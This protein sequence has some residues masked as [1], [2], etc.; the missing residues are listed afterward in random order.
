MRS[1]VVT[2][3]M[4]PMIS[5]SRYRL[6]TVCLLPF[7]SLSSL[8]AQEVEVGVPFQTAVPSVQSAEYLQF[9][10]NRY[11]SKTFTVAYDVFLM[12]HQVE[13]AYEVAKA[14]VKF[15]PN[16]LAW[17]KKLAQAALWSN[18]S[19][20]ALQQWLYFYQHRIEVNDYAPKI[21]KLATELSNYQIQRMMIA[22]LLKKTPNDKALKLKYLKTILG[23]GRAEEG[24][25]Y[26]QQIPN[27]LQDEDYL[28]QYAYIAR[29]MANFRLLHQYLVQWEKINPNA[30]EPQIQDA[31]L[32]LEQGHL[33]EAWRKY[34]S[35]ASQQ[36]TQLDDNF[37]R[38]YA[39]IAVL[40]GDNQATIRGYRMLSNSNGIDKSELINL[41]TLESIEG[42]DLPVYQHARILFKKY[43]LEIY[44]PSIISLGIN[45][46]KLQEVYQFYQN[47]TPTQQFNFGQHKDDVI[48]LSTL[49]VRMRELEKAYILWNHLITVYP[50]DPKVQENFL[51]FLIDL[52]EFTQLDRFLLK[53]C[54]DLNEHDVLWKI[55]AVSLAQLGKY[56]SALQVTLKHADQIQ[57]DY[58][59]LMDL[60]DLY[61]QTERRYLAY[62]TQREASRLLEHELQSV[63]PK[64]YSSRQLL[65][66]S[67]IVRL[68]GPADMSYQVMLR[69]QKNL[70]K[71]PEMNQQLIAYSL[72]QFFYSLSH[73]LI[74][75]LEAQQE[76]VPEWMEQT[77]ALVENDRS[78]LESLLSKNAPR[79]PH[80]DRV[81]AATRIEE[82]KKAEQ[83]AYQGL[84]DHPWDS[85]MY[86]LFQQ[87][88]LPRANRFSTDTNYFVFSTLQGPQNK[89]QLLY[90]INPSLSIDVSNNIWLPKS[91]NQAQLT[92]IPST[93]RTT[94]IKLRKY[95]HRGW[96]EVMGGERDALSNMAMA[97]L[98]FHRNLPARLETELQLNYHEPAPETAAMMIGGMKNSANAIVSYNYNSYNLLDA[99]A[100]YAHYQGQNRQSLGDGLG[101]TL[102][103]RHQ[104]FLSYPDWNANLYATTQN[105][106]NKNT[107]I[108]APLQRL[109]PNTVLATPAFFMP[110]SYNQ[111]AVTLDVGQRYREEYSQPWRPFADVGL[112]NS[113]AFGIG[114]LL[115]LGMS[116]RLLGRDK[117][118]FYF[119]YSD[120]I[121]QNAQSVYSLGIRYD[122]YY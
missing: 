106:H 10:F 72:E 91:Y 4:I 52:H 114:R 39:L 97:G 93:D 113:D 46:N 7:L 19:E 51:W 67:Q 101:G 64:D 11:D 31:N 90:F 32:N 95:I 48:M 62:L 38:Q 15:N 107:N 26:L 41:I 96:I 28:K 27:S 100:N 86:D 65:A 116:G 80:R 82:Y 105:F 20:D 111:V 1:V 29:S 75:T 22:D 122:Y 110:A 35:I 24:L 59:G 81:I 117:L 102:H 2:S 33:V 99:Q 14:A 34:Q 36:S 84:S 119:D 60:A 37:W 120:N 88:M 83:L 5:S 25:H 121:G 71:I 76:Y 57:H 92:N 50:H 18:H 87:T 103:W 9:N 45:L 89:T 49:Y 77:L 108:R 61:Q 3:Q 55:Y 85:Q 21:L 54:H 53:W 42:E 69:I 66:L 63:A 56:Q 115:S 6:A 74:K 79:L 40:S 78:K 44:I 16:D 23:E 118:L 68:F 12:N 73:R 17:R 98:T 8:Y 58:A 109:V 13:A 47:L 112:T 43:Q 94:G 104:F 30:V 70:F